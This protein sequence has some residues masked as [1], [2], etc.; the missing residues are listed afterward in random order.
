MLAS[1]GMLSPANRGAL[2]TSALYVYVF[3][4]SPVGGFV[5]ARI[6]KSEISDM[7]SALVLATLAVADA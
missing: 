4:G 6:Y 5:S 1:V 7:F 3:L 2:V